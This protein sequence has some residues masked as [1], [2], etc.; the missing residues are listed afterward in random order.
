MIRLFRNLPKMF[1]MFV[2]SMYDFLTAT[3]A[4]TRARREQRRSTTITHRKLN[5]MCRMRPGCVN[6]DVEMA[7]YDCN[8][9][10][11]GC[12]MWMTEYKTY[13]AWMTLMAMLE[14]VL[15]GDFILPGTLRTY[16]CGGEGRYSDHCAL[17]FR[18]APRSS[19]TAP[20][21]RLK[22]CTYIYKAVR[23]TTRRSRYVVLIRR[24]RINTY[25]P[26]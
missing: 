25:F 18:R 7:G 6:I 5:S 11:T 22:T 8:M 9:W 16:T 17:V 26:Y 24:I 14:I 13:R 19:F 2:I 12:A 1:K 20:E 3:L 4:M 23:N 10:N 15:L 21:G